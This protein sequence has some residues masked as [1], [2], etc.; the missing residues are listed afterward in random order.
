MSIFIIVIVIIFLCVFVVAVLSL[1]L[2]NIPPVVTT[3]RPTN[4]PIFFL[5]KHEYGPLD[6]FLVLRQ[7]ISSKG[8][9]TKKVNIV[10][11]NQWFMRLLAWFLPPNIKFAF[12]G[13]HISRDLAQKL[14]TEDVCLFLRPRHHG[15]GAYYIL[16]GNTDALMVIFDIQQ[17]HTGKFAV[18]ARTYDH[19]VESYDDP[20]TFIT[21]LKNELYF[22]NTDL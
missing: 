14:K 5:I 13:T 6:V 20:N 9:F 15:T 10:V 12:R 22:T 7:I 21:T 19:K 18:T 4:G 8:M 3:K 17:L 16:R 2:C 1:V 11:T